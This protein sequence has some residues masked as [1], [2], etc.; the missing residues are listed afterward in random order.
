[1]PGPNSYKDLGQIPQLKS[2]YFSLSD[3]S[4][5]L[6]TRMEAVTISSGAN[7]LAGKATTAFA[8][9]LDI[10]NN[11]MLA[12]NTVKDMTENIEKIGKELVEMSVQKVTNGILSYIQDKQTEVLSFDG[13]MSRFTNQVLAYTKANLMSPADILKKVTLKQDKVLEEEEKKKQE[14]GIANL[15][16]SVTEN[17]GKAKEVVDNTINSVQ[18]G[19]QTITAYVTNGPQWVV[20]KLNSYIGLVVDKSQQYIGMVANTIQNM[21][22]SAIDSLA[23]GIGTAAAVKINKKAEEV[24]AENISK[25]E[26][27]MVTVQLK[28]TALI[29]KALMIVRE[30]TGIAVPLKLPK[31]DLK[32]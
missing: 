2:N 18:R 19:V 22:N 9:E 3:L 10:Y 31:I 30:L 25:A 26:K 32:F 11:S 7:F 29:S 1:M 28:A 13:I 4:Q 17:F 5:D 16:N 14:N 27:L 20:T 6:L 24:A 15:K 23:E 21:K 8:R 12:F